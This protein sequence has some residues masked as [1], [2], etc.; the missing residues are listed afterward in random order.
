MLTFGDDLIVCYKRDVFYK[1]SAEPFFLTIYVN[2]YLSF[3]NSFKKYS[4]IGF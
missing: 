4:I 3:N 1:S 2:K